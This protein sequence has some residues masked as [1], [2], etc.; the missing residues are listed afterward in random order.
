MILQRR[1]FTWWGAGTGSLGTE[2]PKWGPEAKPRERV[3]GQ[4]HPE[5]EAKCE[6]TEQFIIF[7]VFL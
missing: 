1:G 3:W 6:I 4:I 2:V 5:S 7:N